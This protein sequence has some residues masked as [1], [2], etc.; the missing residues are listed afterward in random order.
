MDLVVIAQI[1]T[2][3]AT[4]TVALVLVYQLRQQHKD[5]ERELTMQ[6]YSMAREE[7]FLIVENNKLREVIRK[8]EKGLIDLEVDEKDLFIMYIQSKF[9]RL[10][11]E[12]RL[13][14]MK[15]DPQYYILHLSFL[16]NKGAREYYKLWRPII[17]ET[18]KWKKGLPELIDSVYKK[19]SEQ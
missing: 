17:F 12:W 3:S 18:S 10:I 8:A 16:E 15:N 1:I 14:R 11:T 7:N 2:G 13:G 5:S 6:S 9:G 4:L 19:Y